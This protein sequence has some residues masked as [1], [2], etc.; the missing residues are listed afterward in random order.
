M[1]FAF[2]RI[3]YHGGRASRGNS[4]NEAICPEGRSPLYNGGG[5][6]DCRTSLNYRRYPVRYSLLVLAVVSQFISERGSVQ[7]PNQRTV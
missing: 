3:S 1:T 4:P 6:G 5:Y 7:D 2:A